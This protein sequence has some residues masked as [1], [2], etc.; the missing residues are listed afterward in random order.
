MVNQWLV[1]MGD[2]FYSL[3]DMRVSVNGYVPIWMVLFHGKSHLEMDDWGVPLCHETTIS[4]KSGS[5][6]F[7]EPTLQKRGLT[8]K[9][10]M[11]CSVKNWSGPP[12][13]R[14]YVTVM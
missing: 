5:Y 4:I 9:I 7:T 6:C 14:V 8:L 12:F 11:F 1:T 2:G 10:D 13:G 3:V